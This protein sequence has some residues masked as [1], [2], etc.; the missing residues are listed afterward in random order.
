MNHQDLISSNQT[1]WDKYIYH[2]FVLNLANG[3]L[4]NESYLHYLVQDY[5]FLIQY[6]RVY[7]L[8][9]YKSD[10]LEEMNF[11]LPSLKALLE[12]EISHHVKYCAKFNI[13][14]KQMQ[15][16]D[17]CLATV[18]YTRFVL[19]VA[20]K[21]SLLELMAAIAPCA[22]GYADIGKHFKTLKEKS[23]IYHDFIDLYSGDEYQNDVN[24]FRKFFDEKLKVVDKN[25]EQG[26]RLIKIFKVATQ[27]EIHFWQQSLKIKENI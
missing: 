27:M 15:Q 10:N 11:F 7:A 16:S 9:I 14:Q 22:F 3:S 19:D 20:N 2:D 8:A 24:L 12:T 17:E 6:A 13:S 18:A 1:L 4:E 25:Q 21:N 23:D 5:L 26:L